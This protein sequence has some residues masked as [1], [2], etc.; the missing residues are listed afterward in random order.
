VLRGRKRKVLSFLVAPLA[1]GLIEEW[2]DGGRPAT[3]VQKLAQQ[4]YEQHGSSSPLAIK[5]LAR[6]GNSGKFPSHCE[7]DLLNLEVDAD[8]SIEVPEVYSAKISYKKKKAAGTQE[9]EHG[10]ILPHDWICYLHKYSELFAHLFLGQPGS[11][12]E[13]WRQET[14]WPREYRHKCSLDGEDLTKCVPYALHGDDAGVFLKEKLLIV[15]LHGLLPEVDS[16]L[17]KLLLTVMPYSLVIPDVTINQILGV[18]KWSMASLY[19]GVHPPTDHNGNPWPANSVRAKLGD[20]Q[21]LLADGFRFIWNHIEGDWKFH[22]EIFGLRCY[23]CDMMCHICGAT[24][25]DTSGRCLYTNLSP[26]A[27]WRSTYVST[28]Q[29]IASLPPG[30]RCPLYDLPGFS[31]YRIVVD[32]MHCVDLG[33]C[34]LI[35]GSVFLEV[36]L[37]GYFGNGSLNDRLEKLYYKYIQFCDGLKITSRLEKF[38]KDI[39]QQ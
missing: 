7:R 28:A 31:I 9:K 4:S 26:E 20:S 22:K 27:G 6:L 3:K 14:S 17:T 19:F 12:E 11:L 18:I 39:Q 33:I 38:T 24:K 2:T 32:S 35:L 37:E 15:H 10:F 29:H 36:C 30:P 1:R 13:Y 25:K 21:A 16:H 34:L 8:E 23:Q 5:L